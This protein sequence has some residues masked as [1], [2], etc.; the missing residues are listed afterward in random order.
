MFLSRALLLLLSVSEASAANL[1]NA[2]RDLKHTRIIGGNKAVEDRYAYAVSLSDSFGHF[3][4]GSLI[5]EDVI[6]SAAHCD[7]G[8]KGN[9]KAIVGRHDHDDNDGQE[10]SVKEALPHPDYDDDTT[11]NDFMLVFLDESANSNT[12]VKINSDAATPDIGAAVTVM[13][14]GDIDPSDGQ[15]LSD[16]LMEVQVNVIT[17]R[18]CDKSDGKFGSYEDQITSNM[19]CAREEGGGEDSCQGDSGGPLVI[20]GAHAS[21]DVQVGVVS[22]GIGCASKDYPGVY[23]RVSAQYEW[24]K[25][26]VCKGSKNPPSSF[27]CEDIDRSIA[28]NDAADS[29]TTNSGWNAIVTEEFR[30][31]YGIFT[32]DFKTNRAIRYSSAKGKAG[33]IRMSTDG[34]STLTSSQISV[35]NSENKFKI[36]LDIYVVNMS[37]EDNICVDYQTST[38]H[39]EKCWKALHDI[40][41]SE[42]VTK[43]FEFEAENTASLRLRLRMDSSSAKSDILISRVN[44]EG[45]AYI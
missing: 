45:S 12:F 36:S 2:K 33:V 21:E 15:E 39:G 9:Y 29:I 41:I 28:H 17:N 25:S 22:W 11:D 24:I 6:L 43:T 23:A 31:G 35:A 13:G 3:C 44:I 7:S 38:T 14:W 1:R 8:G 37:H 20:K 19:L 10:L 16:E 4:G 18:E 42:W 27:G 30:H 34:K 5:A 40:P 26:E 32:G